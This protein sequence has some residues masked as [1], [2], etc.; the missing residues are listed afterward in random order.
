VRPQDLPCAPV[1]AHRP[2]PYMPGLDMLR[3]CAAVAVLLFHVTGQAFQNQLGSRPIGNAFEFGHAGVD[4]FFVLS[5]FIILYSHADDFGRP[6][7]LLAYTWKRLSRVYPA[8]WVI[9]LAYAGLALAAHAAVAPYHLVHS[10]LLLPDHQP[11]IAVAWTLSHELLF[12][13]IVGVAIASPAIGLPLGV[14]WLC[15]SVLFIGTT[16]PHLS[17]LFSLR[18]LD[19]LIGGG[20]AWALR[21]GVTIPIRTA[22]FT[23]LAVFTATAVG[24]VWHLPLPDSAF[25]AAYG[26]ASGLVVWSVAAANLAHRLQ[27][28]RF[29]RGLGAASYSLYLTHLLAFSLVTRTIVRLHLPAVLP[30]F[31]LLC[32]VV[33][34]VVAAGLAF[35]VAVERPLLRLCRGVSLGALLDPVKRSLPRRVARA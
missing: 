23:G 22:G 2:S 27:P 8:Y 35:H 25:D 15:G 18:H 19:F 29:L 7:R 33:L 32:L 5:G 10:L 6:E 26:V 3:G 16:D 34:A 9:T 31:A 30:P 13:G 4:L 12:Y 1:A 20:V 21:R 28:P 17:F 14:V 11:V 24:N